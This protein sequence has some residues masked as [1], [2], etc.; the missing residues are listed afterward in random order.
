MNV[1]RALTQNKVAMFGF[2]VLL[3]LSLIAIFGPMLYDG[4]PWKMVQRPFIP[5][6]ANDRFLLGTDTLGRDVLAGLIYG[7]RISLLVGLVSTRY[8]FAYRHSTRCL[9]GVFR[10]L[11]R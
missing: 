4:S 5:P 1:I 6:F 11:G 10:W 2:A 7:A 8:C 9:C 3:L